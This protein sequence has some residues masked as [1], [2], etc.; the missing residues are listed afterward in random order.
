[1]LDQQKMLICILIQGWYGQRIVE[2]LREKSPKNWEFYIHKFPNKLPIIIDKLDKFMPKQFPKCDLL[3]SLG[4][5][6]AIIS[7]LPD[8]VK[9]SGAKAIVAPVDN[10]DWNPPGLRKQVSNEL[11]KLGVAFSFPK[12]FCSM[13]SNSKNEII[14][15]FAERFG[16]PN[17]KITS[18]KGIIKEIKVLR[19]APCGA[20]HFVTE[21]L[22]GSSDNE[23]KSKASL[24]VQTYPCLASRTK[25]QECGEHLIHVAAYIIKGAVHKALT[26]S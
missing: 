7:L 19:G 21:K 16:A 20:T 13:N 2:N 17:L 26:N 22:K 11:K 14:D 10:S 9:K 8:L 4:E 5:D 25:D 12:P 23:A 6:P 18:E 24:L 1:M 3:I 15:G